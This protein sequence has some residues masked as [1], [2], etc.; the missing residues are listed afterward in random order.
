M[1]CLSHGKRK[2]FKSKSN[3]MLISIDLE[4]MRKVYLVIIVF[5]FIH[6]AVVAQTTRFVAPNGVGKADG[7]TSTDA[8]DFLNAHF[9]QEIQGLLRK[10]PITVKFSAGDYERAYTVRGLRLADMGHPVNR[11]TLEGSPKTIFPALIGY[12]TKSLMLSVI[13]SRN[14]TIRNIHFT[15]DGSINYVFRV[16]STEE[17]ETRDILIENCSWT[18]MGGIVYGTAGVQQKNTSHVTFKNCMFKNIGKNGGS[19]MIYNAYGAQNIS[20]I[21]SHFEDCTGDYVRFRASLDYALVSGS[22]FIHN[23]DFRAKARPFISMPGFNKKRI[24]LFATNYAFVN[25]EFVDYSNTLTNGIAFHNYGFDRLEFNYLL[26]K[27]EG[28]ILTNGTVAEK[29]NILLKNFGINMD[30]V[31]IYNN[32]F[33]RNIEN[34]VA[35]GSFAR[36]GAESKGWEGFGNIYETVNNS[37]EP[38]DWEIQAIR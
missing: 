37:S 12:P 25:N 7:S 32:R 9:W 15:G 27:E 6:S 11:L 16:T 19:H 14:I 35:L 34:K 33:S 22:I 17:G 38:F 30:S 4:Q 3:R 13:D 21:D 10:E 2:V 1:E 18:D 24:E 8:A 28:D 36:F 5:I 26:T 20:I 31:R 29:K 23:K